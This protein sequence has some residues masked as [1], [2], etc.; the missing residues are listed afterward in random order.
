[1]IDIEIGLNCVLG[2]L[3]VGLLVLLLFFSTFM[4]IQLVF[5]DLWSQFLEILIMAIANNS[6]YVLGRLLLKC[7]LQ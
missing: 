2:V 7:K 6:V 3:K 4:S 5:Y 1:M